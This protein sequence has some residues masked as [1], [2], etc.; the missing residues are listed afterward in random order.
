VS[1]TV[2]DFSVV[3]IHICFVWGGLEIMV[4]FVKLQALERK[5]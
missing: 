4:L 2:V 5:K 1:Y 3:R